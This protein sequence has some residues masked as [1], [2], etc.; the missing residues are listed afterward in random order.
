MEFLTRFL[1]ACAVLSAGTNESLSLNET[2][3]LLC[4]SAYCPA[5]IVS[6]TEEEPETAVNSSSGSLSSSL[7]LESFST[8][9]E[10]IYVLAG[11]YLGCSICA[12]LIIALF[13]DPISRCVSVEA[14]ARLFSASK[15]F[16]DDFCSART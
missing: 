7:E 13:V 12:A 3:L 4:G 9:R 14:L 11:I 1:G 15:P 6:G 5:Q 2:D 8:D 10:R 16:T